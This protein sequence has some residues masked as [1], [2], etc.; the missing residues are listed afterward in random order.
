M[1]S[2]THRMVFAGSAFLSCQHASMDIRDQRVGT[3]N[4]LLS[5]RNHQVGIDC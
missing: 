3:R 4:R 1:L 2:G 5:I